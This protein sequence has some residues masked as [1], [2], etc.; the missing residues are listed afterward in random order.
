MGGIRDFIT[1]GAPPLR[2]AAPDFAYLPVAPSNKDTLFNVAAN[3]L[4]PV[5]RATARE[6]IRAPTVA[7]KPPRPVRGFPGNESD[8]TM[9]VPTDYQPY[10]YED[11]Y[12]SSWMRNRNRGRST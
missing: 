2:R 10:W 4:E 5:D 9:D 8:P 1:G 6:E 12:S 3:L 11:S 7:P